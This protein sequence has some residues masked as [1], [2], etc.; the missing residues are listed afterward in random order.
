MSQKKPTLDSIAAKFLGKRVFVQGREDVRVVDTIQENDHPCGTG[1]LALLCLPSTGRVVEARDVEALMLEE[2]VV[3]S[4]SEA[5]KR[6]PVDREEMAYRVRRD[7][8]LKHGYALPLSGPST[9]AREQAG[10]LR[11]ELDESVERPPTKATDC[12]PTS[13]GNTLTE[14][15]RIHGCGT[16][17]Q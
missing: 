9:E 6:K 11:R 8:K 10:Q 14:Y 5:A 13:S 17:E 7:F 1:F 3:P 16:H 4:A 12:G 15:F 2:L